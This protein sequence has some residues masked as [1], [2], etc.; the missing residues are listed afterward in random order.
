MKI[1]LTK[2]ELSIVVENLKW[3]IDKLET[4]TLGRKTIVLDLP[5]D[6]DALSERI[7]QSWIKSPS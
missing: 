6:L 1:E 7:L 5:L 3:K 4:S 2:E